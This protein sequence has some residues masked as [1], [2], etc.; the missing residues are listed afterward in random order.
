MLATEFNYKDYLGKSIDEFINIISPFGNIKSEFHHLES[1]EVQLY[2]FPVRSI[3]LRTNDAN[4]VI[5]VSISFT[6]ILDRA[7]YTKMVEEFGLPVKIL[8][9]G[10]LLS[11]S[12]KSNE[13]ATSTMQKFSWEETDIENKPIYIIWQ[14]D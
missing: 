7:F 4:D 1:S 6:S 3:I 8:K 5:Q 14:M 10:K 9:Q 12:S 13:L 11:T 2:N